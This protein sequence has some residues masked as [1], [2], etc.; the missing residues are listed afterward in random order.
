MNELDK[1]YKR[2]LNI[3]ITI[4]LISNYP[5]IY[6]DTINGKKVTEKLYSDHGFTLGF[7]MKD[8]ILYYD[9]SEVFKILRKY[10]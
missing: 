6:I 9:L 4:T 2:L 7:S 8:S 3:G 10:K 1:F 5:W